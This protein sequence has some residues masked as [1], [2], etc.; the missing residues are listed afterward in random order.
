MQLEVRRLTKGRARA[1]VRLPI[2]QWEHIGRRIV[3]R[4]GGTSAP[5]DVSV[6]IVDDASMR[7]LN[8]TWRG[9]DRPTD[10][11][12]FDYGEIIISA[13]TAARQAKEHG[14]SLRDE[15]LLL[16]THGLLH[17]LGYD[18]ERLRDRARMAAAEVAMLGT[19]GLIDRA[20][21]KKK[22][23]LKH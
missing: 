22:H 23:S 17:I 12:S 14:V 4:Y 18:H 13:E 5:R 9:Q 21:E 15:F 2:A 10:V 19:S 11:L 3:R 8:R 20:H 7:V 1:N 6:A 16:F